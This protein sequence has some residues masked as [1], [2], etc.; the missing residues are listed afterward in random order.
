L[1][2]VVADLVQP[3]NPLPVE[4]L[5]ELAQA[6]SGQTY[7]FTTNR[8][9]LRAL[10]LEFPAATPAE[11]VLMLDLDTESGPRLA[12]VGLDGTYRP[13]HGGRPVLARGSWADDQTFVIEYDEGPG[14]SFYWMRL[15]FDGEEVE[16][17][18]TDNAA[19][20]T[21]RAAGLRQRP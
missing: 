21:L 19:G 2:A 14:L 11:A 9:G 4:P 16:L 13:S 1:A 17:E 8:L 18:L 12:G 10:R 3:L 5:P 7:A 20:L 6:V 15:R